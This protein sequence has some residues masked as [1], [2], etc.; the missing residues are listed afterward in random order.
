MEMWIAVAAG[1][2][3]FLAAGLLMALRARRA[4]ERV[5]GGD[6]PMASDSGA[7]ALS[8]AAGADPEPGQALLANI[9]LDELLDSRMLRRMV[10]RAEASGQHEEAVQIVVRL[11]DV[12]AD[13]A[14]AFLEK[15]RQRGLADD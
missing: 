11:A 1:L 2:G 9:D 10:A 12:D 7:P 3:A 5:V 4:R 13:E 6:E 15:L 8:I 14:R